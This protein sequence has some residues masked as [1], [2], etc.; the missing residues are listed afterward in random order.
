[1]SEREWQ[2]FAKDILR[3]INRIL[4]YT[5]EMNQEEFL[6]DYK[7]FD[8]VMRNLEIIGEASKSLP[9]DLKIRYQDI[10][11]KKIAGLRDIVIHKYFG[12][13]EDIIWD[14]VSNKVPELKPEIE[15]IVNLNSPF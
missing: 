11:W 10:E 8:A 7:T 15:K 13:D 9:E 14:V 1:M 6:H 2:L 12:I 5:E 4:E 3:S